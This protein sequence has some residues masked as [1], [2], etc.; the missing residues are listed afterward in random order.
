[1]L[2]IPLTTRVWKRSNVLAR[3][4]MWK[5]GLLCVVAAVVSSM[6]SLGAEKPAP[7]YHKD[8]V[9]ILQKNCQDCHRPNQV[10]PS[11]CSPTTRPASGP[12]TWP[13]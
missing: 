6:E 9:R 10:A 12:P 11:R 3:K 7:T 13:M 8:V 4:S 5:L 2:G 1:M